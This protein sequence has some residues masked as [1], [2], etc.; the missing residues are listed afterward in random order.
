MPVEGKYGIVVTA[1]DA[2]NNTSTQKSLIYV[3]TTAP[4]ASLIRNSG[5]YT[6]SR[7]LDQNSQHLMLRFTVSDPCIGFTNCS[8]P[9][10]GVAT[11]TIN[12][13]ESGGRVINQLPIP[14]TLSNGVWVVDVALPFG[15]PSGFYQVSAITT[16]NVGNR[17]E[18]VVAGENSSIEVDTTPP[19]DVIASPSPYDP[20]TYFIGNQALTGRVSD[21]VDGRAAIHKGM[22]V[23]LDFEAPDGASVFDNRGDSRY[24]TSC[25]ICPTIALDTNDP[26]KRIARFNVDGVNQS[27]TIANAATVLSGTFGIALMVKITNGGTILATGIASNPRLRIKAEKVGTTFKLTAQR[28]TK[29][30]STPATI[31]ANVWYYLIYSEYGTTMSLQYGTQLKTMPAPITL[32][33]IGTTTPLLSDVIIGAIQSNATTSAKEDYYSGYVDDI[34]VTGFPLTNLDLLGTPISQGSG[35]QAAIGHQL[36]LKIMDDGYTG[37]DQLASLA[38]YY[39]PINQSTYPLLDSIKGVKSASCLTSGIFLGTCPQLIDGFSSNAITF[40]TATDGIQTGYTLE[41]SGVISHSLAL[42]FKIKQ[43]ATSGVLASLQAPTT[44][45]SMAMQVL[46]QKDIQAITIRMNNSSAIL[47]ATSESIVSIDDNNWH[48]LIITSRGT[49]STTKQIDIYFDGKRTMGKSITGNWVNAQLGLGALSVAPYTGTSTTTTAATNT[50]VDDVAV[51]NTSLSAKDMLNYSYG[52]ST[53]YHETFDNPSL[54]PNSTIVENSP[55]NQSSNVLSSDTT[56]T[57]VVGNV[58]AGAL[59]FDGNDEIVHRDTNAI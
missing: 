12:V 3:D 25:T 5:T 49:N 29:A 37:S 53:V 58:G 1:A 18:I 54:I 50:I 9:G 56:L 20:D 13:K 30:I 51:F 32:G 39:L 59:R 6:T 38:G 34:M 35:V 22:R 27:L 28:G 2:V 21:Y 48:T 26:T 14:A 23:R 36:R 42:R 45:A 55:F 40:N 47:L 16:D 19:Q 11:V 15:D 10:S 44:V 24:N 33:T 8:V 57:S 41:S 7:A 46:Y 52:Y 43:N 4:T 31:P 17:K